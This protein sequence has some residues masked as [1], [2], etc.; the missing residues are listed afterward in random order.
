MGSI[1]LGIQQSIGSLGS[2]PGDLLPKDFEALE[3]S[4]FP[5]EGGNNTLPHSFP[6]FTFRTYA[7]LAFRHFRDHF[8]LPNSRHLFAT[9]V[10]VNWATLVPAG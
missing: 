10:F 7:P 8:L 4:Q 3:T 1:Q 5:S 6:D 9:K 2:S